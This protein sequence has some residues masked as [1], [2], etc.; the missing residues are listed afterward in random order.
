[1]TEQLLPHQRPDESVTDFALRLIEKAPLRSLSTLAMV[2][3]C[4]GAF[5]WKYLE[6]L[7]H[8]PARDGDVSPDD[9]A[10]SRKFGAILRQ[11]ADRLE[12][13]MAEEAILNG[14]P[15]APLPQGTLPQG[16][17]RGDA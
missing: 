15:D 13:L 17:M 12:V 1:M 9:T 16:I 5:A 7:E 14:D 3:V 6:Q 8:D 10:Y 4:E 2:V 11:A